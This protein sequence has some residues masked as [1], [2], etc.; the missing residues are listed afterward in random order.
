MTKILIRGAVRARKY[1]STW[2]GNGVKFVEGIPDDSDYDVVI[3]ADSD[4]FNIDSLTV[5]TEGVEIFVH[6]NYVCALG[7][8]K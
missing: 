8:D 4:G 3:K 7:E 2:D 1:I 6:G 5:L